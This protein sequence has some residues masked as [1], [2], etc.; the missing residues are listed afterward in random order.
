MK[1]AL[2]TILARKKTLAELLR[3]AAD[4]AAEKWCLEAPDG[5]CV[6][7]QPPAKSGCVQPISHE[8]ELIGRVKSETERGGKFVA[9]LL[10]NWLRQEAEKRQL[11]SETLH[12]Y[13][14]INLI[15]SFAEKL[16]A[17]LGTE[18]IARLTL[19]EARQIIRARSG[20]V[21]FLNGKTDKA[22]LLAQSDAPFL[23]GLPPVFLQKA[24]KNGHSEIVAVPGGGAEMLLI[25][26]MKIGQ[27]VLGSLVLRGEGFA[28]ADL[29]LLSTLAGL[30]GSALE[31]SVQ[32]ERAT[33][34]ALKEQR[35]KLTLEMAMKNPFFKKLMTLV[36]ENFT[37]PDYS[38]A[39]LAES[40]HLSVSQL[41]R[42]ISTMT[43]L[44]P[45]QIIRDLRL[46]RAKELLRTTD[47]SVAEVSFQSG[48]NDPS[49]FARTFSKEFG[50][51]PT[52]WKETQMKD[53]R[54]I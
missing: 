9:A 7:G 1:T 41:Q 28:A 38:V 43:E 48:F 35:E 19:S 18:P 4:F 33:A 50:G 17:T 45:V 27:R 6:F 37:S 54:P 52:E 32:H 12:L 47:L 44:T 20:G 36:E 53:G 39:H 8:N 22:S 25:G 46:A 31:N 16:S 11:G 26:V 49:Y 15:F 42:K 40:L 14:E 51:A 34:A 2:A 23:D 5:Q 3:Q 10:E 29:K 13:R 30:A 24:L 21:F